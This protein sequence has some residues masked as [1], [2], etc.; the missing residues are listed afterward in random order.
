MLIKEDIDENTA[1][2]IDAGMNGD[3][4]SYRVEKNG[5]LVNAATGQKSDILIEVPNANGG[6]RSDDAQAVKRMKIQEIE[7]D[8]EMDELLKSK[9]S[10]S[11]KA[12]C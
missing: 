4:L 11:Q 5:G 8:D 2:Y 7:D 1:V 3:G 10:W 6:T 12:F 9:N